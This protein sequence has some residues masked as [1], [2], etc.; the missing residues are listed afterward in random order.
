MTARLFAIAGWLTAGH[1]VL[2]GLYWLLLAIPESNV[3]MLAASALSGVIVALLFGWIEGGRPGGLAARRARE[4]TAAPRARAPCRAS[5]WAP[6]SS[7]WRGT[8]PG[9]STASGAGAAAR[10]TRG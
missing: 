5:G 7:S 3:A 10:S 2:F 9:T 1:V 4:R 8:W 6:R